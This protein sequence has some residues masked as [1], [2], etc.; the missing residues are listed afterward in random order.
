MRKLS[1]F[2]R[3]GQ[4]VGYTPPIDPRSFRLHCIS[5]V[6]LIVLAAVDWFRFMH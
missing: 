4:G 6:G 1:L 5:I 2:H 3:P